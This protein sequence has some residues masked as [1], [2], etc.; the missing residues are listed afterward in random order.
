MK[1]RRVKGRK[2]KGRKAWFL[3]LLLIL[4]PCIDI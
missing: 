2:E 4:I 3:E 1:K